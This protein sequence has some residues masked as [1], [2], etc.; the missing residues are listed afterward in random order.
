MVVGWSMS[1]KVFWTV[2][3]F[4]PLN[5][6]NNMAGSW[7]EFGVMPELTQAVEEMGWTYVASLL[8]PAVV[9]L[10]GVTASMQCYLLNLFKWLS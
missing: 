1:Q 2:L 6:D 9:R 5:L 3:A 4:E 10:L 7:N 8:P